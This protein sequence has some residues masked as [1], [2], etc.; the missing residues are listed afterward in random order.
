VT[1]APD[2][3]HALDDALRDGRSTLPW[4]LAFARDGDPLPALWA[5]CDD[6][7]VMLSLA[8][9]VAPLATIEAL[10]AASQHERAY[11]H[12]RDCLL[13][14]ARELESARFA[15]A[16]SWVNSA[17]VHYPGRGTARPQPEKG[18]ALSLALCD[19]LRDR[20]AL[21]LGAV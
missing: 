19:A 12:A 5:A 11:P 1:L 20:V 3:L 7:F 17:V 9:R 4:A 15:A 2:P 21:T 18:R 13:A 8:H 10:R 16:E 14:A 6:P